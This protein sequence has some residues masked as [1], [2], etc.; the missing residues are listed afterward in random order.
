MDNLES[1]FVQMQQERIRREAKIRQAL[2]QS[3]MIKPHIID[4]G[5]TLLGDTLIHMGTRLKRH[6]YTRITAAEATVPTFLIML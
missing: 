1:E 6:A 3:G 4:R 2:M 5:F